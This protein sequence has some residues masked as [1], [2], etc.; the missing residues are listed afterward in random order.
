MKVLVFVTQLEAGGAQ[1]AAF[2]L[3]NG[4]NAKKHNS[5]V[6]FLYR[7]NN[8]Y[9]NE[10][11]KLIRENKP[12][13]SSLVSFIRDL[14]LF[15]RDE[16]PDA[17]ISFT[18]YSNILVQL[19]GYL[20]GIK[21]RIASQRNPSYSYPLVARFL[22]RILGTLNLYSHNVMV[23]KT[24][25]SSFDKYP[26]AYLKRCIV[27]YNG[28]KEHHI[29]LGRNAL[30][31]K[32]NIEINRFVLINVGRLSDQKNQELLIKAIKGVYGIQLLI[33]GEGELENHLKLKASGLDVKF[34]GQVGPESVREYLKASDLFVFPSKFEGMS[35]ALL[36]ALSVGIPVLVSS[37]TEQKE[38]L[39]DGEVEYGITLDPNDHLEWRNSI[40]ALRDSLVERE[41]LSKLSAKRGKHFSIENMVRQFEELL[42]G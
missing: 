34:L 1:K 11:Y 18:Y 20:L 16:K 24:V 30:R 27:I 7:K 39:S 40:L 26:P 2:N 28:V 10:N 6:V 9:Q 41:H 17:I 33:I 8:S 37:I 31:E 13:I 29:D 35:N 12:S 32:L 14:I 5:Q 36:E 22:D 25:L 23:S 4:L 19:S 42:I 21:I 3:S 15:L 38:V